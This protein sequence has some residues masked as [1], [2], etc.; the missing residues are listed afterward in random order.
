MPF[1]TVD[2]VR[3]RWERHG[4]GEPVF[5]VGG[6]GTSGRAWLMHQVPALV[7][8]GYTAY[9]YDSRGIPPSDECAEGFGVDDLVA[10]LAGLIE[11]LEPGPVRLV[12]TSMGAYVVQELALA[13]PELVRSAVLM[14]SRAHP[15][16]LRAR[17]AM[18]EVELG[19]SEPALPAHYRATVRAMQMLSPA[20]LDDEEAITDWLALLELAG[21]DGPGVRAQLALQPMPDRRAAYAGVTA[22]CHVIAFADDLITP[23]RHGRALADSI[24][25]A[26]FDL[27]ED[28]GHFGY[29]ERPD[30]VNAI[31]L[32]HLA[33]AGGSADTAPATTAAR[34]V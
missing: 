3:L 19:D 29:L 15:D 1:V 2:G 24:P 33:G 21:P 27:V 10:D 30:V 14:A 20:T 34:R 28:A 8:A 22:P 12:G 6:A 4:S 9:V 32:R 5:L 31:I 13:R 25:G 7:E 17:L 26:G 23:P 16:V 18:A 11:R